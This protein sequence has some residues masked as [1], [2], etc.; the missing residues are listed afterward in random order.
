MLI[1]KHCALAT[2]VMPFQNGVVFQT[3][4]VAASSVVANSVFNDSCR[5]TFRRC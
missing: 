3:L 5:T 1:K 2:S 4:I